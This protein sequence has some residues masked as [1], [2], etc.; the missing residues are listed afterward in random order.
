MAM[1]VTAPRVQLFSSLSLMLLS[2]VSPGYMQWTLLCTDRTKW[3]LIK[4]CS[5]RLTTGKTTTKNR[6]GAETSEYVGLQ[7]NHITSGNTHSHSLCCLCKLLNAV[8]M[9]SSLYSALLFT[10]PSFFLH[11][12]VLLHCYYIHSWE[13]YNVR[14]KE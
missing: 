12:R 7:E 5:G 14:K 8:C 11:T 10:L 1:S 13:P 3:G 2:V 4:E 6:R 9:S